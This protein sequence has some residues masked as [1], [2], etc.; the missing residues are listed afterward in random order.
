MESADFGDEVKRVLIMLTTAKGTLNDRIIV[1]ILSHANGLGQAQMGTELVPIGDL[2]QPLEFYNSARITI[3]SGTC[4]SATP[5]WNQTYS[6]L[7]SQASNPTQSQVF[8]HSASSSLAWPLPRSSSFRCRGSFFITHLLKTASP[9]ANLLGHCVETQRLVFE[10]TANTGRFQRTGYYL[11]SPSLQSETVSHFLPSVS[12]GEL[13]D[14]DVE[15]RGWIA[16]SLSCNPV[17][18]PC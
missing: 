6:A 2:L 7:G 3:I 14:S 12:M 18:L 16:E 1:I 5:V 9:T 17:S 13:W 11:T 8:G 15:P 10:N 4:Y